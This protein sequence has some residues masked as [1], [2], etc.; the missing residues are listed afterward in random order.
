[1]ILHVKSNFYSFYMK[2]LLSDLYFKD[3][4]KTVMCGHVLNAFCIYFYDFTQDIKRNKLLQVD[5][6]GKGV[7][8]NITDNVRVIL[9]L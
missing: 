4:I 7:Q 3:V 2:V 8:S 1:M 6:K 9:Q 5:I